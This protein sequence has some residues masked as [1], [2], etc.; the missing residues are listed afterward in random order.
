M[1]LNPNLYT[2]LEREFGAVRIVCEGE[3]TQFNYTFD[4]ITG[5]SRMTISPHSNGE[6]YAVNCPYCN[7]TRRRLYIHHLWGVYNKETDSHNL[8]LMMCYNDNCINADTSRYREM[9]ERVWGFRNAS[10]RNVVHILPGIVE[11]EALCE[12]TMPGNWYNMADL[13]QTHPAV[14]YLTSRGYDV[15]QLTKDWEI[16]YCERALPQYKR[17]QDRIIVP[18]RMDDV[19]YGWQCRY[20][21]DLDWKATG[22]PKY[23]SMPKM[24]KRFLFYNFDRA[25]TKAWCVLVEGPT[26]AWNVGEHAV[27]SMGKS[28]STRQKELLLGH[29]G[30][31]A[32]VILFDGDAPGIEATQEVVDFLQGRM[33]NV[34]PVYLPAGRDPGNCSYEYNQ[35][36]IYATAQAKGIDLDS[37]RKDHDNG[38]QPGSLREKDVAPGPAVPAE[39][40]QQRVHPRGRI[41]FYSA[42]RT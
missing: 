13:P 11:E 4:L 36:L 28:L 15:P 26:S 22:V 33:R 34:I 39:R 42:Q 12:A 16:G 31:G 40:A 8:W 27:A 7:D 41:P 10:E 17:A 21:G 5:K 1:P 30:Q 2:L 9:Q 29:W 35:Q 14:T 32:V 25:K 6:R 37:L 38:S 23:Y 19:L 18:V 3:A 20:V 24:A